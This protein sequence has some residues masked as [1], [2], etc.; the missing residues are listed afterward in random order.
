MAK[1]VIDTTTPQPN[2]KQGEPIRTAFEKT[3]A[4]FTE[5]YEGVGEAQSGV[6]GALKAAQNLADLDNAAQARENLELGT[7]AQGD[8]QKLSTDYAGPTE[9]AIKWPYMTWADTGNGLLKR[10]NEANTAWIPEALL[11]EESAK[12]GGD[13]SQS[14]KAAPSTAPDDVVVQSQVILGE[15]LASGTASNSAAVV[16]SWTDTNFDHYIV[17]WSAVT[18]GLNASVLL[19]DLSS[20]GGVSYK[21]AS[22]YYAGTA[23]AHDGATDM[24]GSSGVY[25]GYRIGGSGAVGLAVGSQG[26]SGQLVAHDKNFNLCT[27]HCVF[28]SSKIWSVSAAHYGLS[29]TAVNTLRFLMNVGT[30]ASG[31]FRIYGVR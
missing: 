9:P 29:T 25:P 12:K 30:T 28:D 26:A 19:M 1:Q 2:G 13:A 10:R 16:L 27:S 8:L 4:N 6:N 14:F 23:S 5:L 20:N 22:S 3:N 15:L 7:A 17:E 21:T 31:N 24:G 18:P 11:F